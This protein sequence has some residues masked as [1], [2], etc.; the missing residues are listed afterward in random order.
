MKTYWPYI[1]WTFITLWIIV[2][3]L[4][5]LNFGLWWNVKKAKVKYFFIKAKA[6]LWEDN[7]R[8]EFWLPEKF[9]KEV[10]GYFETHQVEFEQLVEDCESDSDRRFFGAVTEQGKTD[11]SFGDKSRTN[12]NL[13]FISPELIIEKK[14]AI[15][16]FSLKYFHF[17]WYLSDK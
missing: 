13:F 12:S 7:G 10:R 8:W 16:R 14:P 5:S 9:K 17:G 11:Y 15:L 1:F 4:N 2:S 6:S 3:I